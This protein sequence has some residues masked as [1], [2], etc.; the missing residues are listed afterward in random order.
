MGTLYQFEDNYLLTYTTETF[1]DMP[2][3]DHWYPNIA[4]AESTCNDLA[5]LKEG[6]VID[7]F[8]KTGSYLILYWFDIT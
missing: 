4:K 6:I 7:C 3:F 5:L 2:N 8:D 1:S